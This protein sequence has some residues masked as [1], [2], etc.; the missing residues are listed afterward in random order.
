MPPRKRPWLFLPFIGGEG[1]PKKAPNHERAIA[2]GRRASLGGNTDDAD[3]V[4]LS[5]Q[6]TVQEFAEKTEEDIVRDYNSPTHMC[7][8]QILDGLAKA[9]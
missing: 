4:Q 1:R 9:N 8:L 2:L 3:N 5:R 7:T 6:A